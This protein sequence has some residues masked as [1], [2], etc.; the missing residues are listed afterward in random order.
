MILVNYWALCVALSF[1]SQVSI[2]H[3]AWVNLHNWNW[4]VPVLLVT[5]GVRL[6]LLALGHPENTYYSPS[7]SFPTY[8]TFVII[9]G[10]CLFKADEVCL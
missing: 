2:P 7:Q 1:Y 6:F 9:L 8:V 5:F 4:S 3:L 10:L